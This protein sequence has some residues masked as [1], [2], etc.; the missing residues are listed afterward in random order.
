MLLC[1]LTSIRCNFI[2]AVVEKHIMSLSISLQVL[3]LQLLLQVRPLGCGS[4]SRL[5]RM[6]CLCGRN[7][8]KTGISNF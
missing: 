8:L 1:I 2:H 6:K 5:S 4:E 7:M 3:I